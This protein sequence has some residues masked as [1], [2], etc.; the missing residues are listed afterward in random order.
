VTG[1]GMLLLALVAA[2]SSAACIGT[3]GAVPGTPGEPLLLLPL[4]VRGQL[5]APAVAAA[6]DALRTAVRRVGRGVVSL[7]PGDPEAPAPR[8]VG[9]EPDAVLAVH[10]AVAGAPGLLAAW[11]APLPDGSIAWALRYLDA[12]AEVSALEN[13]GE[14]GTAAAPSRA[15]PAESAPDAPATAPGNAAPASPSA[16]TID[17]AGGR[18]RDERA[19]AREL[20]TAAARLLHGPPAPSPRGQ[21]TSHD[22]ARRLRARS[23]RFDACFSERLL[24]NPELAGVALLQIEVDVQGEVRDVRLAGSSFADPALEACLA[25]AAASIDF[26]PGVGGR[27]VLEQRLVWPPPAM[28]GD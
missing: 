23:G 9:D 2:T 24:A 8:V 11:A 17:R 1:R 6:Q 27:S 14:G 13:G 15:P 21:R 26:P 28:A 3:R 4:E 20:G 22:L 12:A 7:P 19:L 25:D 18:A 16:R 10:A 5:P